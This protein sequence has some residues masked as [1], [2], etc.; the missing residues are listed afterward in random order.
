MAIPRTGVL[1]AA[2]LGSLVL[3]APLAWMLP[4]PPTDH[5][6]SA[7]GGA[8]AGSSIAAAGVAATDS[9]TGPRSSVV[10]GGIRSGIS[11]ATV[12]GGDS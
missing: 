7:L 1:G 4:A 5:V 11:A 9:G 8:S 10:P 3:G 12:K 6:M 2:A